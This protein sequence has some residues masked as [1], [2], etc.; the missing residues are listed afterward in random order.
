MNTGV[1]LPGS[2]VALLARQLSAERLGSTRKELRNF[3]NRLS[4]C[5]KVKERCG[6]VLGWPRLRLTGNGLVT[7]TA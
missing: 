1:D 2:I 5:G 3:C 7:Y 4:L 6:P